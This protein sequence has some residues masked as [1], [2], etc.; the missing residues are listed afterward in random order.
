MVRG[1]IKGSLNIKY[2]SGDTCDVCVLQIRNPSDG[3]YL[4]YL[5]LSSL[6]LYDAISYLILC[7][8]LRRRS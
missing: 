3:K 7:F 5:H 2:L 8:C 4:Q 1:P 6:L